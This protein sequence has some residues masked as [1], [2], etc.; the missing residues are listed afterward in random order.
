MFVDKFSTINNNHSLSLSAL[1]LRTP[2][3]NSGFYTDIW[4]AYNKG[5]EWGGREGWMECRIRKDASP[6]TDVFERKCLCMCRYVLHMY[7]CNQLCLSICLV[8]L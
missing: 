5:M 2:V 1:I 8:S 4:S 6:I 7:L 3:Q